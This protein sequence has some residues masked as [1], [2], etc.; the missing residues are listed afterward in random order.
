MPEVAKAESP[1][2][3]DVTGSCSDCPLRD[4]QDGRWCGHPGMVTWKKAPYD[5]VPEWCL[6][7]KAPMVVRLALEPN[8]DD[9]TG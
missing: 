6:L 4:D 1:Y 7:R 9:V 5:V 8:A 3:V 2:V